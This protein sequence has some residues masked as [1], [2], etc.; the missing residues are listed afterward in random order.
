M[1]EAGV[2]ILVD[3]ENMSQTHAPRI[4]GAAA[5]L[6]PIRVARVYGHVPQING[7]AG[8][9]GFVP[10]HTARAKDGADLVLAIE[11]VAL[12]HAPGIT[13]LVIATSDGGL[14]PLIHHLR[15]AGRAVLLLGEAKTPEAL[16]LAAPQFKVLEVPAQ[17]AVPAPKQVPLRPAPAPATPKP[18]AGLDDAIRRLVGKTPDGARVLPVSVLGQR[19]GTAGFKV[20][21]LGHATWT[22]YLQS[23]PDLCR[24]DGA[25]PDK[26]VTLR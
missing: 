23:R 7:W 16:R 1:T 18:P 5:A 12:S 14:A 22:R 19:L 11:A 13:H 26:T 2:A 4:L 6:G 20:K 15:A 25:G 9:A 8:T 10:M 17:P 24:I 3:G 21:A